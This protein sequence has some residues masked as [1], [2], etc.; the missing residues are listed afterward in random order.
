MIGGKFDELAKR[1]IRIDRNRLSWIIDATVSEYCRQE[2][3]TSDITFGPL[4]GVGRIYFARQTVDAGNELTN[5]WFGQLDDTGRVVHKAVTD[6]TRRMADDE[7]FTQMFIAEDSRG[8]TAD[9]SPIVPLIEGTRYISV[10][11][12]LFDFLCAIEGAPLEHKVAGLPYGKKISLAPETRE[13]I[14]SLI[15]AD[16]SGTAV[17]FGDQ[18]ISIDVIKEIK[19]IVIPLITMEHLQGD[20]LIQ[21]LHDKDPN[22]Q[23]STL[24]RIRGDVIEPVHPEAQKDETFTLEKR[25]RLCAA[26]CDAVQIFHDSGYVHLDLKPANIFINENKSAKEGEPEYTLKLLDCGLTLRDGAR[27][28]PRFFAGTT[29]HAAPEQYD[30]AFGDEEVLARPQMDIFSLSTMLYGILKGRPLFKKAELLEAYSRTRNE[31]YLAGLETRGGNETPEAMIDNILYTCLRQNP[32][33]RYGQCSQIAS[34]LRA[35]SE[36]FYAA[37]VAAE[38]VNTKDSGFYMIQDGRH[39]RVGDTPE[40]VFIDEDGIDINLEELQLPV[41]QYVA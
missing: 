41:V 16:I 34:Q 37:P 8:K 25:L 36:K 19:E 20:T 35:V 23:R 13:Y 26:L 12:F 4:G 21:Y 14:S 17:D 40:D 28:Q 33:K 11:D 18:V 31:D 5:P 32:D 24:N 1:G 15:E 7:Y 9:G 2:D 3:G 10:D 29:T 27:L 39:V 22:M 6:G 30:A 38:G